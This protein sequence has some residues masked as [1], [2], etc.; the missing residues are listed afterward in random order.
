M[1]A[2]A[3]RPH[4]GGRSTGSIAELGSGGLGLLLAPGDGDE[5]KPAKRSGE[6]TE[7]DQEAA[8]EAFCFTGS[9]A[10]G[11]GGGGA[12]AHGL[13]GD[14]SARGFLAG[15]ASTCRAAIFL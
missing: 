5:A 11:S 12:G 2:T 8:I 10:A 9:G 7:D 13:R 3:E 14:D 6:R 1:T 4:A 15:W